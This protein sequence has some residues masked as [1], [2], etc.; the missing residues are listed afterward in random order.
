[1]GNIG[2]RK[3]HRS[4]LNRCAV[5]L[6]WS[7]TIAL[8]PAWQFDP[9]VIPRIAVQLDGAPFRSPKYKLTHL[10]DA[11]QVFDR[12]T[13]QSSLDGICR[14]GLLLTPSALL[15]HS[16]P[17]AY[18]WIQMYSTWLSRATFNAHIYISVLFRTMMID[19]APIRPRDLRC[20]TILTWQ[21]QF[22]SSLRCLS[23]VLLSQI[24][25]PFGA[26]VPEQ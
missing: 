17:S 20:V 10:G 16:A 8:G 26:L 11:Q 25:A 9:V 3:R 1:M 6:L 23:S 18:P 22:I 21:H 14:A 2:R 7:H 12:S 19:T 13:W 24:D 5:P 4:P 15:M